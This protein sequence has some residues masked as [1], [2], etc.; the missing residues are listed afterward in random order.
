MGEGWLLELV[1]RENDRPLRV[2]A[3]QLVRQRPVQ[4]RQQRV[5]G[6]LAAQREAQRGGPPRG[7]AIAGE[8]PPERVGNGAGGGRLVR[9]RMALEL[10][11]PGAELGGFGG[12]EDAG[13]AGL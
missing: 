4:P 12:G 9:G 5:E 3:P 10:V 11:V 6:A 7:P 13:R 1:R 8:E 2:M